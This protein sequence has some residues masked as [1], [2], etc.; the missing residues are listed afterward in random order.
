MRA[1]RESEEDEGFTAAQKATR[2]LQFAIR[3]IIED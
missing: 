1:V 3:A 2:S